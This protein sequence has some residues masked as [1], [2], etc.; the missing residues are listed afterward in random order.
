MNE[1]VIT[2]KSTK[3][4]G[5]LI[6]SA[7]G[8]SL[9]SFLF[10]MIILSN[11]FY[12]VNFLYLIQ[13][14]AIGAIGVYFILKDNYQ[15]IEII[16][17]ISLFVI[18]AKG[19]IAS[20]IYSSF[21]L[22]SF[23]EAGCYAALGFIIIDNLKKV[24]I[25]NIITLILIVYNILN[26]YFIGNVQSLYIRYGFYSGLNVS[27]VSTGY[28]GLVFLLVLLTYFS[29]YTN[30]KDIKVKQ[31]KSHIKLNTEIIDFK[32]LLEFV[33]NQYKNG[34]ITEEEY[35]KKRTEILNQL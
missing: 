25:A 32:T 9:L 5:I 6:C 10:S 20:F 22:L 7:A 13:I 34:E 15:N 35:K 29:N 4:I 8:L 11:G 23:L 26:A 31:Y 24:K 18:A 16:V 33:E 30:K 12:F 28:T 3:I 19:I 17:P 2:L 14:L 21:S 1:K 27:L